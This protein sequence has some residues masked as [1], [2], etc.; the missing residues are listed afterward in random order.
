[1]KR[2]I[3]ATALA[4]VSAASAAYAML[5]IPTHSNLIHCNSSRADTSDLT[6]AQVR[7]LLEII[8]SNDSQSSKR[9]RADLIMQSRSGLFWT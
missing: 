4:L 5:P 8:E 3:S 9:I 1:M 2:L 6:D 7:D